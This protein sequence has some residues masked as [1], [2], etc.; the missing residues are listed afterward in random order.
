MGGE[1]TVRVV[2]AVFGWSNGQHRF[3]I[4]R[5]LGYLWNGP[6]EGCGLGIC[7]GLDLVLDFYNNKGSVGCGIYKDQICNFDKVKGL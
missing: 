4:K 2:W 7:I 1:A 6:R 5:G 3:Y